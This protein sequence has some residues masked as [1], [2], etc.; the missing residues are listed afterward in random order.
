MNLTNI[1]AG[2]GGVGGLL[3]AAYGIFV[4]LKASLNP[5]LTQTAAKAADSAVKPVTE[6]AEAAHAQARET[7]DDLAKLQPLFQI[8]LTTVVPQLHQVL[9]AIVA[10]QQDPSKNSPPQ[11]PPPLP[12]P[13]G[14][15]GQVVT[16]DIGRLLDLLQSLQT[17]GSGQA[18]SLGQLFGPPSPKA[19]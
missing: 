4:S 3:A 19:G 13:F 2:F 17:H 8:L 15:Q 12:F 6:T 16:P 14:Q 1:L 18:R 5:T 7:A 10:H 11:A 9:T